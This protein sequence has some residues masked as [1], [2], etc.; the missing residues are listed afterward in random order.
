[1]TRRSLLF[2]VA[3][4]LLLVSPP[5]LASDCEI[6]GAA[7]IVAVGDVHGAYDNFVK[8]LRAAGVIDEKQRWSGGRTHLVQLGDVVDRGPDSRKALDLLRRLEKEAQRAKGAVH[9]LLGN[10][11]V[12]WML[13]DLRYVSPGEYAAFTT[14]DSEAVR[15]RL[16]ERAKPEARDEL[17]KQTPLGYVELSLA[18]APDGEYGK[19][20]RT[21]H[22]VIKI[23]GILFLHGGISPAVAGMPCAEINASVGREVTE[24]LQQTRSA[25][26][27]SLAGREDGPL[28]Y[29]GLAQE[30]DA[31]E[32]QVEQILQAQGAR[33]IVIAHT[34]AP[35]GRI[36][37]R[38]GGRVF[39]IDTGMLTS[40]VPDGRASALEIEGGTF[41][42]IYLDGREVLPRIQ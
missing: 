20:L 31:W 25:P 12:M 23:D 15:E 29:R 24:D 38:F 13:G 37:S 8:I 6:Q 33:A 5:L 22:A 10:H 41:K 4:R 27:K 9:A 35:E 18:F 42:A 17:R 2:A 14:R 34:P 40:Y 21:H 39:Q 1:V 19:W 3:L 32:P 16:L 36:R 30:P 28:W 26:L 11:E 7:R